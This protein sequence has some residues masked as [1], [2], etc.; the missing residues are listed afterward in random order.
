MMRD[1]WRTIKTSDDDLPDD[2]DE[3]RVLAL[4]LA[5]T[6]TAN[7]Y[8]AFGSYSGYLFGIPPECRDAVETV[9]QSTIEDIADLLLIEKGNRGL[10]EVYKLILRELT[11]ESE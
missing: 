1:T 5:P 8:H 4:K 6:I 7:L 2:F 11:N 9:V 10:R 3:I